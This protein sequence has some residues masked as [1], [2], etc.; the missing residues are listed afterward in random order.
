MRRAAFVRALFGLP[1]GAGLRAPA[2]AYD[3]GDFVRAILQDNEG[4]MRRI[5]EDGFDP[6]T[7]TDKG[8]PG[9]YLALEEDS[10]KVARLLVAARR[11]KGE[12]RNTKDESVL[13]M[14]A[15][16]G[17]LDIARA[18]IDKDADVN[19]PGWTPLHYAATKGH[20]KMMDL[21][22]EHYA[23]IDAQAP[24]GN[25]PLMMAAFYSTPE[26]VKLLIQ[27]GADV[28]MRNSGGKTALDLA[29]MSNH[30]NSADLIIEALRRAQGVPR[31]QW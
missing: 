1:L 2:W 31:G 6:N 12:Q 26:A 16:K 28:N 19:K 25:T 13:M 20:L 15:Y 18:L 3:T 17:D 21:L 7:K 4:A 8:V 24:N 11:T 14:A 9:L 29:Q 23:F 30:R 10:L 22:L 27:A 5:L